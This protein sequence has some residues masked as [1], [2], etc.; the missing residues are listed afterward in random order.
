[1]ARFVL[2]ASSAAILVLALAS[3]VSAAFDCVDISN[4]QAPPPDCPDPAEE[5]WCAC[6]ETFVVAASPGG[7]ATIVQEV[8]F[9]Y[10]QPTAG[11]YAVEVL[12]G[13]LDLSGISVGD[14]MM[15]FLIDIEIGQPEHFV[16][17]LHGIV[18]EVVGP[19][20]VKFDVVL[21]GD[22]NATTEAVLTYKPTDEAHSYGKLYEGYLKSFGEGKG[23]LFAYEIFEPDPFGGSPHRA[24]EDGDLDAPNFS[25]PAL[26]TIATAESRL[27]RSPSCGAV[28]VTTTIVPKVQA[29]EWP[30]EVFEKV[31]EETFDFGPCAVSFRRGDSDGSGTFDITDG[32]F[33][34][35]YLFLGGTPVACPDA[36][37]ANDDGE[38][39]ISDPVFFLGYLF[40]GGQ[41][42]PPPGSSQCGPDPTA[43]DL[44][45]CEYTKC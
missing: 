41:E 21:A 28:D 10:H 5:P 44:G 25:V 15:T 7:P 4:L 13:T 8:I 12:G 34:L 35:N 42:P 43:D 6:L 37:D 32:V 27:Y 45:P 18:T 3:Y 14:D 40:L 33:T 16:L 31:F 1:M 20:E 24:I 2:A 23:F 29:P 36:A 17:D 9:P 26:V 19:D 22:V 39:N 30:T 38:L 11:S